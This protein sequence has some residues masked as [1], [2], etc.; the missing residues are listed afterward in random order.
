MGKKRL[1]QGYFEKKEQIKKEEKKLRL[2][3][4]RGLNLYRFTDL[5]YKDGALNISKEG[6]KKFT[7]E[8]PTALSHHSKSI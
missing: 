6:I 8:R 1:M 7:D 4:Q 2:G 3:V 5:K